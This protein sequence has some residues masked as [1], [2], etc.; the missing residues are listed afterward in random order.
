MDMKDSM[1]FEH[2]NYWAF[3]VL[4]MLGL[5]A[6]IAKKNLI[7]KII[8]MG[9][10]QSSIILFYISIATKETEATIPIYPHDLIHPPGASHEVEA[11]AAENVSHEVATGHGESPVSPS[12]RALP[13]PVAEKY[14]A[15]L[16]EHPSIA[17]KVDPDTFN[18]P[19]PHVLM[20]TAI[21]VG[22]AT[23]GVALSLV[24]RL[25]RLYGT[26]EEDAVLAAIA[27]DPDDGLTMDTASTA[28]PENAGSHA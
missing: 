9:I 21:V 22:V 14:G 5:W 2:L 19:L 1:I 7:K 26:I 16:H 6:M 4:M 20:L 24:Q 25:Y 27:S 23:L 17:A 11:H 3:I 8:G 28:N 13:D 10:F 18:N 12:A 15:A